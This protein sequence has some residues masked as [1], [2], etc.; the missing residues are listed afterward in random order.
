[1][2]LINVKL[3]KL[4]VKEEGLVDGPYVV[5]FFI[6]NEPG[7]EDRQVIGLPTE[8]IKEGTVIDFSDKSLK[9]KWVQVTEIEDEYII[10]ARVR[11]MKDKDGQTLP[12]L[13]DEGVKVAADIWGQTFDD[14]IPF[15]SH[16]FTDVIELG[17]DVLDE[18]GFWDFLDEPFAKGHVVLEERDLDNQ[19]IIQRV[20]FDLKAGRKLESESQVLK[21]TERSGPWT[22]MSGPNKGT[23]IDPE[24]EPPTIQKGENN[25]FIELMIEEKESRFG[26]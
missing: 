9:T 2:S 23:V 11:P 16:V 1:M 19:K 5:E 22:V 14:L 17:A 26:S 18:I 21:T 6:R 24:E 25:G 4:Q 20:R 13:F 3:N 7:E 12:E 10:G 15:Q 8:P